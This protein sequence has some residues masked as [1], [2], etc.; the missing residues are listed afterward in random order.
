MSY[1]YELDTK[2]KAKQELIV[3]CVDE[4]TG[5]EFDIIIPTGSEGI[6]QSCGRSSVY[7]FKRMYDVTFLL[8]ENEPEI[9]FFESDLEEVCEIYPAVGEEAQ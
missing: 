4:E 1:K 3:E 7:G 5:E 2:V 6:I 8:G 9:T